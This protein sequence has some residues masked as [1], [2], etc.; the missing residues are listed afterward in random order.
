MRSGSC[1]L[2]EEED[3]VID[4]AGVKFRNPFV[5]ASSP[6]TVKP[7]LL[8]K[9]YDC[10]AAAASTKLTLVKQR[11]YKKLRMY[12]DP[13]VGSI[14]CADRRLDMDE[15]ARLI[16]ETKKLVPDLVLFANITHEGV[17]LESWGLLA[18]AMENA[19]AD[20]IEANFICPNL[21]LTAQQL[22]QKVDSGG[23]L[24]GQ[25]AV[26]AREVVRVLKSSVRIPVVPKLT[27]NVTDM[28]AVALACEE[29]A[30]LSL[31]PVDLYNLDRVYDLT[32]G[33]SFGSLG[34]PACQLPGYFMTAQLAKRVKIP[35]ISGGGI[36]NWQHAAQYMLWGAQMFQVCTSLMWYG[37]E[38]VPSMLSG[39]DKYIKQMGWSGYGDIVGKALHN[40][41]PAVEL[42]LID[43]VPVVDAEKCHGCMQCL[44]PGHC[45]AIEMRDGLP[46]IDREKCLGCGAC[47]ALCPSKAL[48]FPCY[49]G[50]RNQRA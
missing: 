30:Q 3:D 20:L 28:T 15:G 36:M 5:V 16:E 17:D 40:V 29:G 33:A 7:F 39:L 43:D 14:I 25:S 47:V 26:M 10:G 42:E 45:Y 46:H 24:T 1:A 4:F 12:H 11:F 34:G 41:R 19:G 32:I 9:A 6:L 38:L 18:K 37:Y 22:G 48:S 31:P 50:V 8:Q 13:K 35:I 49:Q 2:I 44:R 23:A 21:A 27:P